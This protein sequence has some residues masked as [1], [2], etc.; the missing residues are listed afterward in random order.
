MM[1]LASALHT[2]H[3]QYRAEQDVR[4]S[5]AIIPVGELERRVADPAYAWHEDHPH[6]REPRHHLCVVAGATR[7][8][9][10]GETESSGTPFDCPLHFHGCDR[11][12]VMG[13][14]GELDGC[15]RFSRDLGSAP[16]NPLREAREF[17]G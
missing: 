7:H 13:A 14:G 16:P 2:I 9:L 1:R 12:R 3:L 17:L 10:N 6:R 5:S 15:F 11:R 4:A 8:A